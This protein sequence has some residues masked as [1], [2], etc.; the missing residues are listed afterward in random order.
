MSRS[1]ILQSWVLVKN[2]AIWR[3]P[4]CSLSYAD[5]APLTKGPESETRSTDVTRSAIGFSLSLSLD[6][7]HVT[8]KKAAA[9]FFDFS[10]R[11]LVFSHP[12]FVGAAERSDGV[13]W[14]ASRRKSLPLNTAAHG[15][16]VAEGYF[17]LSAALLMLMK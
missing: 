14:F 3:I 1:C 16:L 10:K 11:L 17:Y 4:A 2:S 5:R 12:W 6:A 13:P 9:Q 15:K 7:P 8:R